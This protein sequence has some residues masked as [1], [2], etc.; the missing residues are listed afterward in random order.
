MFK[1]LTKGFMIWFFS[2]TIFTLLSLAHGEAVLT[3]S[4]SVALT[5]ESI[6]VSMEEV[7]SGEIFSVT[8]IGLNFEETL[9]SITVPDGEES[10]SQE[11][12]IPSD[13]PSGIYQVQAITQ[14]GE[15]LSAELSIEASLID[16]T[17]N[18]EL[19]PSDELMELERNQPTVELIIIVV[20]LVI[21]AGL[22]FWL[23]M[24]PQRG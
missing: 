23:V 5:G 2:L 20:G 18:E 14:E 13:V 7:E 24:T 19:E 21:S 6:E 11:I 12:A 1:P 15:S 16:S 22:G 17:V 8:L 10:A 4:P 3:V 9:G